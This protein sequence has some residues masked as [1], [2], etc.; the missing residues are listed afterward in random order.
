MKKHL[1]TLFGT[2]FLIPIQVFAH[3]G[4]GTGFIVGLTHPIF[5][6]DHLMAIIGAGLLGYSLLKERQW[7]F[8][9]ES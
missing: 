3:G 1:L 6:L 2:T 4:H 5:G 7:G 9:F 8:L